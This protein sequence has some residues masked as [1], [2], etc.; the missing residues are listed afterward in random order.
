MAERKY[1][2]LARRYRAPEGSSA[3][4][5]ILERGAEFKN[6]GPLAH[7]GI[8]IESGTLELAGRQEKI[9]CPACT[10]DENIPKTK[11]PKF[12]TH[13]E[14]TAHYEEQHAGYAVPS[15]EEV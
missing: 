9:T 5:Q 11:V 7:E 8:L 6:P 12:D 14:L 10:A 2:V 3:A 1:R 15:G 13:A 4:K